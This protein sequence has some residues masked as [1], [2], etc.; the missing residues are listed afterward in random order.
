M[1]LE[2][3]VLGTSGSLPLPRRSLSSILFRREGEDFLFDCGEGVQIN[4]K[5]MNLRWKN[6]TTICISH[7]HADH[8][9]GLPGM[10]MLSSQVGRETP[11]TIICPKAVKNFITATHRELGMYLNYKIE[12]ILLDGIETKQKIYQNINKEYE[13]FA[14][15]GVHT[16]PVWGFVFSE[17]P[18]S[19]KFFP[20][21]ARELGVPMG[22]LWAQLQKGCKV[23][24]EDNRIIYPHEVL[25]AARVGRQ[26]AYVTDTRPTDCIASAIQNSDIVFCEGMFKHEHVEI[27]K[28]KGHMTGVEAAMLIKRA[29]VDTAGLIHFSPRYLTKDIVSIEKEAQSVHAGVFC[30]RDKMHIPI[31]Y[32]E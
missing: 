14:F 10:L 23:M 16:R 27:A 7:S 11:L 31:P 2:S 25:G 26:I 17:H 24:L 8:V 30:C 32:K 20:E 3:Y 22:P 21:L 1:V 5:A 18:R 15:P 28:E 9:T 12:Y 6:L 13:I 29:G 19:G 4:V